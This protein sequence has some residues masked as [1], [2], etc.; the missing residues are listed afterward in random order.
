M[1]PQNVFVLLGLLRVPVRVH[2]AGVP[3]T[4]RAG[5]LTSDR[6]ICGRAGPNRAVG[7]RPSIKRHQMP[8]DERRGD[9]SDSRFKMRLEFE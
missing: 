4:E 2:C 8:K 7:H 3:T 1:S 6:L 5:Q 9:E